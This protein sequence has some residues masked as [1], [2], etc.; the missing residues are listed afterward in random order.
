MEEMMEKMV[1]RAGS[2][3][4]RMWS[5]GEREEEPEAPT[6][7]P[8]GDL[9]DAIIVDAD[10]KLMEVRRDCVHQSDRA[11]LVTLRGRH[12]AKASGAAQPT[13]QCARRISQTPVCTRVD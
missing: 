3:L 5:A 8:T 10:R 13:S 11:Q 6:Q 12:M 7:V 9:P 2:L 1:T 4:R